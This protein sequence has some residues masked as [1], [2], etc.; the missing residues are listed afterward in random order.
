MPS[1][2]SLYDSLVAHGQH[3]AK[4]AQ[5]AALD[6]KI[7]IIEYIGLAKTFS[8]C[9]S[10][11]FGG[12][13]EVGPGD[14]PAIIEADASKFYGSYIAYHVPEQL[15]ERLKSIFALIAGMAWSVASPKISQA[16]S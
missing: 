3:V 14:W 13:S 1:D 9:C 2:F 4:A 16:G 5:D 8:A 10:E 7:S 12:I 6:G 11:V 15:R